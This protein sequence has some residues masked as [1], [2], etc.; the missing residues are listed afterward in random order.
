M[1]RFNMIRKLLL[2]FLFFT[3][4]LFSFA[5]SFTDSTP[6]PAGTK[7]WTVPTGVTNV[8][9]EIWG[10][11]GAGGGST[12]NKEG[13]AGGGGGAYVTKTISV[14][15]GDV[16]T[17]SIGLGATGTVG[18]GAKGGNTTL[19]T[20]SS[21]NLIANGG[22]GGATAAHN[23]S[24]SGG[25]GGSASGGTNSN[26]SNG[27]N[28]STSTGNGGKGGNSGNGDAGGA[29]A[30][31]SNGG[32]GTAGAT[33]GGGGGGGVGRAS[34]NYLGGNGGNGQVKITYSCPTYSL[35][36]VSTTDA[37][38]TGKQSTV[39]AK[40]S[41]AGLPIGTYTVE[42][43]L[44][45]N[46]YSTVYTATMT[47]STAG[48]GT[49]TS[50]LSIMSGTESTNIRI[51]KITSSS[52][53]STINSNNVSNTLYI[54]PFRGAPTANTGFA[55]C[56]DWVAQWNNDTV[57]GYYLDVAIDNTFT[58]YV[59][60]YQNL[61]VGNVISYTLTGLAHGGTYYYRVR[62]QNYCGISANSNVVSFTEKGNG[63]SN[64]GSISGGDTSI[65][66]GNTTQYTVSGSN[67][68]NGTWS[69]FNQTGA[70][71]I[72]N[73]GLLSA[74]KPGTV[75]VVFTVGSGCVSSTTKSFT[76][77]GG[78]IGAASSTPTICLGTALTAIT[79]TTSGFT[80]IG[81]ASNLPPGTS[82]SFSSNTI[83]I[84][85]T[86][87][88]AGT[89]NYSI[90]L[91]GGS[92]GS[93]N[94]NATG[95]IIVSGSNTVSTSSNPT[96]CIGVNTTSITQTTTGAT[97]IGTPSNLPPG[98]T[99]SWL[100]NTITISGTPNTAGSYTYSIPLTGGCGSIN[101]TGTI[102]VNDNMGVSAASSS[103]TLCVNTLMTNITHTTTGGVTGIGTANPPL[104]AGVT[105][106]WAS[107]TITISGTPS[108]PG[109]YNYSIPV[110]GCGTTVNAI[111]TI[112]VNANM[113]V[114]AASSS[115]TLCA[116]TLMTN[117]THTTTGGVTGIGTANPPLPAGVTASWASNTITI[118]G[119]PS[120]PGTYNYSIPVIGCGTTVNA[121]GSITVNPVLNAS[122]TITHDQL[123]LTICQGT[124]VRFKAH[125]TNGGNNPTYQWYNG[126]T[127]LTETSDSYLAYNVTNTDSFKVV[128]TSN[129]SP[130]L[131]GSPATSN[132]I[133]FSVTTTDRGRTHGGG[134]ICYGA[135]PGK[136]TLTNFDGPG[137]VT[138]AYQ[139]KIVRWEYSTDG[140]QTWTPI[141]GTD[142]LIEYTP[143]TP[144]YVNTNFRAV[145][146]TGSCSE[147]YAI[148]TGF[149]VFA[150][151]VITSPSINGQ[152]K[153]QGDP[154]SAI[155]VSA[156]GTNPNGQNALL[157]QWYSTTQNNN[158]SGSAINGATTN[159]Y[160][161]L[162]TA[163]VTLYYYC[164]VTGKC[165]TA[166][167]TVSGAF[168]TYAKPAAPV[169]SVTIQPTCSGTKGTI[170]ITPV[171]G[172]TYSI[173]GTDYYNQT[174][175]DS[176][177][178]NTYIVTAKNATGCV[179][180]TGTSLQVNTPT[181]KTWTGATSTDWNVAG[182]WSPSGVPT[183]TDCVIIPAGVAKNPIISDIN[184]DSYAYT[185]TV[186]DQASLL[187][188]SSATL[189]VDSAVKVLSSAATAGSLFFEDS[190]SLIQ[191]DNS[192]NINSG[193]ISYQRTTPGIRQADY[194]YWSTPVQGQTPGGISSQTDPTKI[195]YT[196]G[197]GWVS[198]SKTAVMTVGKGYIIRGPEN[199]SNTAR[200]PFT[201][202]FSG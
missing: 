126:S 48:T 28:N 103:Q 88:V 119:T 4:S 36:S 26:G 150:P 178:P 171:S 42:Y 67:P 44:S 158:T 78:T 111:G 6:A 11:G 198:M 17:Y 65:C 19:S 39:T 107:N 132:T 166:S 136:M 170:T 175:F 196:D 197:I 127:L 46:S 182:N 93:I 95:K 200:V 20:V 10:A 82:A 68:T 37:C 154:F 180:S 192:P 153:C 184:L 201:A 141:A 164:I 123:D 91:N 29:G 187:I 181:S 124:H 53:T 176:L 199:Y 104:P 172:L 83:T 156:T 74:T 63:S 15:P 188:K 61:Y 142:K 1:P 133:S 45:Y 98:L 50:N 34:T 55:S 157:Y 94:S 79:H 21:T 122:V 151:T 14:N 97:G 51:D 168:I 161:P 173:N 73:T 18:D 86:P 162:S 70:A 102:T 143:T 189:R 25:S 16:I 177:D 57:D 75:T 24:V 131:T 118:S 23:S 38:S 174:V 35:T 101:A 113:G 3:F 148:E 202:T 69:V 33:P 32:N 140:N 9:L 137:G 13:G 72:S 139:N 138:Y 54:A 92:C 8:T 81:A 87:T 62:S 27:A 40:S 195:Y 129:A 147:Q 125:P 167:S 194:T 89:Y 159:T 145:A 110:I 146:Q 169:A 179:S 2:S 193:K 155:S 71:T 43:R 135:I 105:A 185:L 12:L 134:D 77:A 108:V 163:A 149:N 121:T 117:I 152:L 31:G 183:A 115:Q 99:A 30:D 5:Q 100:S 190:A 85:G 60:G 47:V 160:T 56:N 165:G 130:C 128:M 114:S 144:L 96:I 191:T 58:N 106:L 112:T 66:P 84:V 90:P 116:N 7:T 120:A 59:S 80:G 52:C 22:S 64:A 186:N 49:F 76:I 41:A 109:T